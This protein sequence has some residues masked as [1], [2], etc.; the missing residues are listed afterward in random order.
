MKKK[1]KENK[2]RARAKIQQDNKMNK[3]KNKKL[4]PY[5]IYTSTSFG[6]KNPGCTFNRE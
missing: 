1:E 6:S 4:I 3:M 5:S 2:T